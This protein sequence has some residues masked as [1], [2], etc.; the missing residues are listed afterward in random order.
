ME[1]RRL[2]FI[3]STPVVN[4]QSSNSIRRKNYLDYLKSCGF[5]ITIVEN[6]KYYKYIFIRIL[7]TLKILNKIKRLKESNTILFFGDIYSTFLIPFL[8]KAKYKIVDI[9][10]SYYLLNQELKI[11]NRGLFLKLYSALLEYLKSKNVKLLYINEKD[12]RLD[13]FINTENNKYHIPNFIRTHNCRKGHKLKKIIW[14]AD[15]NYAPNY[16]SLDYFCHQILPKVDVGV[17][18]SLEVF[19]KKRFSQIKG[20]NEIKWLTQEDLCEK[21]NT[22]WVT[23]ALTKIGAGSEVKV[24]FSLSH[25]TPVLATL[26]ACRGLDHELFKYVIICNNDEEVISNLNTI[27]NQSVNMNDLHI[28]LKRYNQ[29]VE[30][31]WRKLLVIF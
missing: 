23:L 18:E 27:Y 1:S 9:C 28:D 17:V 6:E 22:S 16:K 7:S 11:M 12:L 29:K 8:P 10:D 21:I 19:G 24:E 26:K 15:W 4:S 14:F 13:L 5:D 25:G 30:E 20:L 2:V 3:S 31:K